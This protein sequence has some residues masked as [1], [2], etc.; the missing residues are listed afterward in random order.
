MFALAGTLSK[1]MPVS[2]AFLSG[3][4]FNNNDDYHQNCQRCPHTHPFT[5]PSECLIHHDNPFGSLHI[6]RVFVVNTEE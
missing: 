3:Q 4:T 5:H 6:L 2:A 1:Q